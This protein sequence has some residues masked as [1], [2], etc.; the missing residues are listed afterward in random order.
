M[1]ELTTEEVGN[2]ALTDLYFF[3]K[4]VI[5]FDKLVSRVHSEVLERHNFR[6]H[7]E[8]RKTLD[9][10]PRGTYKSTTLT[11]AKAVQ[12]ICIN[13]KIKI[14]IVS[15]PYKNAVKY[16]RT[17]RDLLTSPKIQTLYPY[18]KPKMNQGKPTAWNSSE[19]LVDR[20]SDKDKTPTC[21]A[22]APGTIK[23]GMHY[24]LIILDDIINEKTVRTA[25]QM[26]DTREF[27]RMLFPILEPGGEICMIGT[28]YHKLDLYGEIIEANPELPEK[29]RWD[30]YIRK[31]HLE[32]GK[33]WFKELLTEEYLESKKQEMGSYDFFCQYENEPINEDQKK[34]NWDD[35]NYIE[36]KNI[37]S[38]IQDNIILAV[39]LAYSTEKETR[40]PDWASFQVLGADERRR[41]YW[42]DGHIQKEGITKNI[43]ALFKIA[44][45]W[46]IRKVRLEFFSAQKMLK[47]ILRDYMRKYD[48][49]LDIIPYTDTRTSKWD[50]IYSVFVPKLEWGDFYISERIRRNKAL[51]K[52]F[53]DEFSFEK[54]SKHDDIIDAITL[55]ID[56]LRITQKPAPEEEKIPVPGFIARIFNKTG[57]EREYDRI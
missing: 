38:Y 7:K 33:L 15:N 42:L 11:I 47:E 40:D 49:Y 14:L 50:R 23:T 4:S 28:R 43:Q 54:Q 16:V 31:S 10:L 35:I 32:N 19:F 21:T 56:T 44:M 55:G 18:I 24:D 29:D 12:R 41:I 46:N 9:L 39:D 1:E 57:G 45:K 27:V 30:I 17:I 2:Y 6:T 48:Y 53:E 25:N 13:P 52:E 34:L 36:P 26:D 51:W 22:G 37:P 20:G 3:A 8:T 5:G